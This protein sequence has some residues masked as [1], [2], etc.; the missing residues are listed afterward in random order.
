MDQLAGGVHDNPDHISNDGVIPAPPAPQEISKWEQVTSQ[1][2]SNIHL[3]TGDM[4][5]NKQNVAPHINEYSAPYSV[6]MM[7]FAAVIILLMEE[8][9]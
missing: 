9:N 2:S 6:F 3:I 7:N 4:T 8:T 1:T 5:G